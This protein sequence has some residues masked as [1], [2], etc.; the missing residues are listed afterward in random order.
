VGPADGEAVGKV[1]DDA[2]YHASL[3]P[4]AYREILTDNGLKVESFVI[5][6]PHCNHQSVLLARKAAPAAARIRPFRD[7]DVTVLAQILHDAVHRIGARDYSPEQCAAWSPVPPA[8]AAFLAR[9]R[10]SHRVF[11]AVDAGDRPLGF[12]EL[13]SDGHIDC[14]YCRPDVAGSGVGAALYRHLE[15]AA[16]ADGI[17]AL[18]V[19]A[20]EAAKRFFSRQGFS[21]GPRRDFERNGVAIHNFTMTKRLT[22]QP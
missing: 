11:V 19:E 2:V 22:E 14:F 8:P 9:V 6:D 16:R 12:I 5:D 4:V 17:G 10:G 15:E 21:L 3:S 18:H 13:E 20:S 1:G 7:E